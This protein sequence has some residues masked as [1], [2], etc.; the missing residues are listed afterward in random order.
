MV[1]VAIFWLKARTAR[2][3]ASNSDMSV[4][5]GSALIASIH[6][7]A[8]RM[9]A[10]AFGHFQGL[11]QM[12]QTLRRDH[13]IPARLARRLQRV[14]SA[15]Q[16]TRHITSASAT[17]F[18]SELEALLV[19]VDGPMKSE[20]HDVFDLSAAA[21]STCSGTY[22]EGTSIDDTCAEGVVGVVLQNIGTEGRGGHTSTV[23]NNAC[24]GDLLIGAGCDGRYKDGGERLAPRGRH[25]RPRG[26][27]RRQQVRGW[28]LHRR[29]RHE[30]HPR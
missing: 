1:S 18:Q 10:P 6:A 29:K 9:V 16:I 19:K 26:Q 20:F 14:D 3:G 21:A 8:L 12:S 23:A 15:Y 11:A 30:L 2:T 4:C 13:R 7:Q 27:A 5:E 25:E 17:S 28:R 22:L 24:G